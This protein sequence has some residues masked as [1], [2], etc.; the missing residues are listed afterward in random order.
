MFAIIKTGG[1]QYRVSKNQVL[2]VEKLNQKE[3]AEIV[4]N[5]V[6]LIADAKKTEV[7]KPHVKGKK[8]RAKIIKHGLSDKILVVK[9]KAKVRY[10]RRFGHRQA[11]SEIK[12]IGI[13]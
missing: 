3:G 8:V 4:F 13:E 1:K 7:G 5:E 11:F 12:V 9:F 10:R 6:L 2:R